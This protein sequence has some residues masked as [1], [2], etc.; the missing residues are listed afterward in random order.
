MTQST[1]EESSP[2]HSAVPSLYSGDVLD[3]GEYLRRYRAAPECIDAERINGK[4]FL[5]SPLRATSHAEPHALLSAWLVMYSA[6]HADLRVFDNA[7]TRLDENNDPQP[8][9]VLMRTGGQAQLVDDYIVGS[10]EMI[11]E[12]AGSSASYDFGEKRDIY[13]TAGVQEYLV[14][15][16]AEGRI[17][18]WVNREGRFVEIQPINGIYRSPTFPGLHLNADAIRTANA[19]QLLQCL[20][21]AMNVE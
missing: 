15:E 17:A 6:G 4:V 5:M 11:I 9:L 12:I 19:N 20:R 3:A 2:F 18:W 13:E 8:D 21:D 14:Y 16:T 10:P 7:T 1:H